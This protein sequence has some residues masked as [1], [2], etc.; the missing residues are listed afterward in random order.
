MPSV[1]PGRRAAPVFCVVEA[2]GAANNEGRA[3]ELRSMS[4]TTRL[5]KKPLATDCAPPQ[6]AVAMR[7]KRGSRP[8][9]AR[10][11]TFQ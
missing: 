11:E 5:F 9:L 3:I 10:S 1:Q 7:A 4:S 8:R 2:A 6:G